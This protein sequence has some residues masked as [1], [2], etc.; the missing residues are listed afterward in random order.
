VLC[1]NLSAILL[2]CRTYQDHLWARLKSNIMFSILRKLNIPTPQDRHI[3]TL[4]N[5]YEDLRRGENDIRLASFDTFHEVQKKISL[6]KL[7]DLV[8][9]LANWCETP[10]EYRARFFEHLVRFA[11]HLVVFLDLFYRTQDHYDLIPSEMDITI[12]NFIHYLISSKQYDLVAFYTKLLNEENLRTNVFAQ[13]L[14]NLPS[15]VSEVCTHFYIL[16]FY[17]LKDK[18]YIKK[19]LK[20][21]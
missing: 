15:T 2:G 20:M 18:V 12:F 21:D 3:Q 5:I 7:H 16:I 13:F 19:Q 1:G 6:D 10:D 14:K 4:E 11:S 9:D 8:K 17:R